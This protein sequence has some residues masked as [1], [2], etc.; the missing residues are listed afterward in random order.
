MTP[1]SPPA[2]V[3]IIAKPSFEKCHPQSSIEEKYSNK[4]KCYPFLKKI[5]FLSYCSSLSLWVTSILE[6]TQK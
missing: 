2:P 4:I 5:G 6:G 3:L 1:A